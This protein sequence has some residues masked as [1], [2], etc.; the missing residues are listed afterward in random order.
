MSMDVSIEKKG[1]IDA[2]DR[3][4]KEL[5]RTPKFKESLIIILSNIDPPAVRGLV[6][7]LFWEDPGVL[8]S[9]F[10]ALPEII[11]TATQALAE[12]IA[13]MGSL[14]A[15]LLQDFLRK[16]LAGIDGAP[17]GEALG[18]ILSLDLG[19]EDQEGAI[20]QSLSE[21]REGFN[22]GYREKVEGEV[23]LPWLNGWMARV[24]AEAKEKGS[25]TNDVIQGVTKALKANPDFVEKVMKPVLAPAV[26]T[27]SKKGGAKKGG[28]RKSPAK[29]SSAAGSKE[30]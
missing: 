13:Q 3:I 17:V 12:M 14:P 16:V 22:R 6:R 23:L 11:N 24:A 4:L 10:G 20:K 19:L 2:A 18:G 28:A 9:L 26:K 25:P 15:P 29:G 5:M 27:P 7:T 1:M 21:L 30:E 8:L